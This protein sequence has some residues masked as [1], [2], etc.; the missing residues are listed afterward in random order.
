MDRQRFLQ[1]CEK[2]VN[3]KRESTGIGTLSE[4]TLHAVV[5]HYIELDETK[6]EVKVGS[7][8]AD[9]V[10]QDGIYEIQTRSFNN[11]RK[12][13]TEF[14]DI[15][16]VTVVYPLPGKK[17]LLWIDRKTGEVTK[18]RKSPRQGCLYDAIHEL[19]KIRPLIKHPNFRLHIIFI[20]IEEYR[21]LDGWSE[22]KKKGSSRYDRI[23]VDLADEVYFSTVEDY[24]QF[25]PDELDTHFTS[26]EYKQA[27]KINIHTAQTALNILHHIGALHR[28]GKK[29]NQHIYER[30]TDS[31]N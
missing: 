23:P 18:K 11:L 17:W 13:L 26:K 21:N 19:Y 27:A 16:P 30:C 6:Q 2:V 10:T 9:I 29:G 15:S 31:D 28:V 3:Y 5:K 1:V 22:N 7:F 25:V 14:L 24:L 20:D 8:F 12:K 4:K